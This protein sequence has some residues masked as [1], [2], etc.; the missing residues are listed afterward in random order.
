MEVKKK[1]KRPIPDDWVLHTASVALDRPEFAANR[2]FSTRTLARYHTPVVRDKIQEKA[3]FIERL[4][5]IRM[6]SAVSVLLRRVLGS[7]VFSLQV[8]S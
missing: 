8:V 5:V 4:Q 6:M 1:E 3:Q 7:R 2:P